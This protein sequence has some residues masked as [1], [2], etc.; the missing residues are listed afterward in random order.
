MG[1]YKGRETTVIVFLKTFQVLI[2][3]YLIYNLKYLCI[4]TIALFIVKFRYGL[5]NIFEIWY[6]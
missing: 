2:F 4:V 6:F 5:I 1:Y 3:E